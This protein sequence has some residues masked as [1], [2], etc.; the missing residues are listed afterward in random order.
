M[1]Q[2]DRSIG[3]T[4]QSCAELRLRDEAEDALARLP[5]LVHEL[6]AARARIAELEAS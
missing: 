2:C 4:C 3:C 1:S 5:A 6:E